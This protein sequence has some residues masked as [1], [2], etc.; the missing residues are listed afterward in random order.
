VQRPALASYTTPRDANHGGRRRSAPDEVGAR[1]QSLHHFVAKTPLD[2]AE[3]LVA[4]RSFV[5]PKMEARAPVRA[6]IVDDTGIPKKGKHSAR[7]AA[8]SSLR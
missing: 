4:V 6:W 5:L 3:L 7:F 8:T 1:H 2:E